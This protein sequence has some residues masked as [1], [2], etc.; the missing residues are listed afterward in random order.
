MLLSSTNFTSV[1]WKNAGGPGWQAVPRD[2]DGDGK[3]DFVVY[4]VTTG[5]WWGL[6][7]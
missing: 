6:T 1:L 7:L 5:Q 3:T 2:Y 4:N